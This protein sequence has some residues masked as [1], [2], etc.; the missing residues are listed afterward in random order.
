MFEFLPM[1]NK[2]EWFQNWFDTPYYHLLYDHRNDE[3]AKFFM[4]GLIQF[5]KLKKG[6]RILDL[7]CGKGRHSRFLNSKGFEVVGADLSK[8]SIQAAKL[9]ENDKLKFRIHDMRDPLLAKYNAIF[10]LF[11]SFGYFNEEMTNIRVLEHF[12]NALLPNG[13]IVIDFLNIVKIENELI[14]ETSIN[15]NG[16]NFKINKYFKNDF[17]IKKISFEV[18]GEKHNYIE[19][20]QCLNLIKMSDMAH[21]LSLELTHVFGDYKLSKFDE[22]KSDRLILILQ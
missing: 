17:L 20:L 16:I 1:D 10:N 8:N 7:P 18:K 2:T 19:K 9:Y 6:D 21:S 13:Y 5:L 22:R 11:T 4:K 14:P 12:K 3:E 15:K